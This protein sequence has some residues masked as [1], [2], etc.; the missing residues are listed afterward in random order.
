MPHQGSRGTVV[1]AG[2][3]K[4]RNHLIQLADG[5]RVVVPAGNLN[6]IVEPST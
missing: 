3:G 1:I 4:P 2:K 6:K 5:Q